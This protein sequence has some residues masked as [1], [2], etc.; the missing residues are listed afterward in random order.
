MSDP[1]DDD[2]R[3]KQAKEMASQMKLIEWQLNQIRIHTLV[4]ALFFAL[5][6][7]GLILSVL[8]NAGSV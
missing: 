1:A 8:A 7:V 2:E 5:A 4:V 3:K 6:F